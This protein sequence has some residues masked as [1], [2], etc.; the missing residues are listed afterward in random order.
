MIDK[1]IEF[2]R[3]FI[4][5]FRFFEVVDP[6]QRGV[7]LRLGTFKRV[8]EPGFYFILPFGID[9]VMTEN[10]VTETMTTLP[11]SLTTKDGQA[12][13][14]SLVVTFRISD[15]K[16]FLL[17]VEGRN[18]V[19]GDIAYGATANFI[20]SRTWEELASCTLDKDLSKTIRAATKRYGV[21]IVQV[22]PSDFQRCRSLRIVGR[23]VWVD[24]R[25][26]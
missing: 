5:L 6:Y 16:V 7:Q 24:V 3:D 4:G 25:H 13:V 20:M 17:E 9:R 8:L 14:V 26:V 2:I 15:V 23:P 21:E 22:Q 11:Q 1:L 19:I 12:V 10:V 18:A